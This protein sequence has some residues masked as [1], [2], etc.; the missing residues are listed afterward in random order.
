MTLPEGFGEVLAG[1]V[2]REGLPTVLAAFSL[3][4][5]VS[6]RCNPFKKVGRNASSD[7]D[8]PSPDGLSDLFPGFAPVPWNEWGRILPSRPDFTLDPRFHAGA[9][10]VQD[11]SAMFPGWAVRRVLGELASLDRPVRVLDL[12]AA[13]GGK[14]TDL[15]A[16]LRQAFGDGFLLVANEVMRQRVAVLADNVAV[17]GDPNVIVTCADPKA[18]ARFAGFFDLILADVPCSGEGM[19]RKDPKAVM[20]WSLPAVE[21][22]RARQ[23]RILADV[24]PALRGGGVMAYSTC[25]FNA[26]EDDG[27]AKWAQ[28]ELGAKEILINQDFEGIIRT[29]CGCLLVPGLVPGEGQYCAL[30]RKGGEGG[31]D[32]AWG[33]SNAVSQVGGG[34]LRGGKDR[35]RASRLSPDSVCKGRED[36]CAA[37]LRGDVALSHRGERVIALPQR[38]AREVATMA[39]LNM[40]RSGVAVGTLKGDTLIPDEELALSCLYDPK[41][42]ASVEVDRA[43]ALS[44]L[45]GDAL[46]LKDAP[47]GFVCLTFGGLRL[48]FVKNLGSR[49]NNLH[50]ASRRIRMDINN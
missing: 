49:C 3:P 4:P 40:V 19:F 34:R 1:A 44:Y 39:G 42:F 50:P 47:R 10:Y 8:L 29:D 2:G 24:W 46:S 35:G 15:A 25:T 28:E 45:H 23:R 41:A 11:S 37:M 16:S 13:P 26:E 20:D 30:L 31:G 12:C 36:G 38:V 14:T 7:A 33:G 5:S 21:L 17:W 22:C 43:T 48:G 32:A 18:F 9:Y 27:N 6:V